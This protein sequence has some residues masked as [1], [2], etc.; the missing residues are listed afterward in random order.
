V[1]H[2][3]QAYIR[4]NA[5]QLSDGCEEELGTIQIIHFPQSAGL[6]EK[7][8]VAIGVA[9]SSGGCGQ[10]LALDWDAVDQIIDQLE[11]AAI[12]TFGD[13]PSVPVTPPLLT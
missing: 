4:D 6:T 3:V 1:E 5:F 13:R 9:D 11:I 7:G 8:H 12:R 10:F 2:P